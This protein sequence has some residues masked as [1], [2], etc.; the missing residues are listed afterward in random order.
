MP[1]SP[2]RLSVLHP[3]NRRQAEVLLNL[4][5]CWQQPHSQAAGW[6][7]IRQNGYYI[8]ERWAIFKED[9]GSYLLY[10]TWR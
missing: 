5:M 7:R 4:L 6:D 2:N 3:Q 8:T 10:Y 9:D 1:P